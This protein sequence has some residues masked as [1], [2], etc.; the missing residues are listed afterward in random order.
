[1][2]FLG[3]CPAAERL[4]GFFKIKMYIVI[5]IRDFPTFP[6]KW[7]DSYFVAHRET[8]EQAKDA[9]KAEVRLRGGKYGCVIYRANKDEAEVCRINGNGEEI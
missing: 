2:V 4:P 7:R 3:L 9:A 8:I 1:M 5:A 6:L